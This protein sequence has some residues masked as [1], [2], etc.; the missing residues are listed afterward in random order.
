MSDTPGLIGAPRPPQFK[1]WCLICMR[2]GRKH[3]WPESDRL[4]G[5]SGTAHFQKE[6]DGEL[7][8]CGLDTT[9]GNWSW[10]A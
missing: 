5:P 7:T 3:G 1:R 2:V 8:V 4:I 6:D 10:P 9:R